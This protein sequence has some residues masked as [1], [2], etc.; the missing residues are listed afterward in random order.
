MKKEEWQRRTRGHRHR[1]QSKFLDHGLAKLTDEEIVELLLTLTTPRRDCKQ[2]AREAL[3]LFGGLVG[4]LE[5]PPAELQKVRGIGPRNVVS[6]KLIHEVARKFLGERLIGGNFLTSSQEVYDYLLHS[7]R[8][9]QREIFKVIFLSSRN[10]VL[11]VETLFEG[12]LT[13]S[14]VYPREIIKTA[15]ERHAAAMV[16]AH[17]H[18]SGDPSPSPQDFSITKDLLV[19]GRIMGIRVLDHLIIGRNSYYSFAD[20]GHIRTWEAQLGD[21]PTVLLKSEKNPA[22]VGQR[23][24]RLLPD[25]VES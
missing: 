3:R 15:L 10:E 16:F 25:R 22:E 4:V 13:S 18:P 23:A 6:L 14:A 19:A 24:K 21:R 8:N 17:N 20:H 12:S 9:L 1:L 11:G 5:A 7:L 2:A